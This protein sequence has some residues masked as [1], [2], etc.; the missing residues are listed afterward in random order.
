V[1]T[2]RSKTHTP[3]HGSYAYSTE[4]FPHE[5]EPNVN[6]SHERPY[7]PQIRA[8]LTIRAPS[9]TVWWVWVTVDGDRV[10]V[11][12]G[13]NERKAKVKKEGVESPEHM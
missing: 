13:E 11:K 3:G 6:S 9:G 8:G 12:S 10:E 2:N 5:T 1:D 4:H 7:E